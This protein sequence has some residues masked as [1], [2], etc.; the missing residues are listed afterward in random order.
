MVYADITAQFTG[1]LL[2]PAARPVLP[3]DVTLNI[4]YSPIS[5]KCASASDFEFILTRLIADPTATDV[6]TCGSDHLPGETEVIA[7]TLLSGK[8]I[9]TVS[10][11]DARS[12]T[13]VNA[14]TQA[15]VLNRL[16]SGRFSCVSL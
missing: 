1:D 11:V 5:S 13:D 14:D 3:A 8:C 6:Q 12:K 16:G 2:A 7:T 4:N 9:A 10:V 15:F